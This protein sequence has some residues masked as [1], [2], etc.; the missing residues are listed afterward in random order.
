MLQSHVP[1]FP[2]LRRAPDHVL[3]GLRQV[4]PTADLVYVGWGKWLLGSVQHTTI[5]QW[6]KKTNGQFSTLRRDALNMLVNA[7]RLLELWEANPTFQ[8]NPGAFRRLMGRY[9]F[10]LLATMGFRPISEYVLQGEPTSAIVDA[11]RRMDWLYRTTSDDELDRML[12]APKERQR[13]E[14]RAEFSDMGRATDAWRYLFTR[15]HWYGADPTR[16]RVRSG[17]TRVRSI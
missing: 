10:A 1:N 7:R 16:Q 3:A 11:F 2:Q 4:D 15:S 5:D 17:F 8:A 6:Y 14:A 12:D 13:E 9:D